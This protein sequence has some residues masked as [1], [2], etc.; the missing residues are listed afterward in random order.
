MP[1]SV[2]LQYFTLQQ[3][4][5]SPHLPRLYLHSSITCIFVYLMNEKGLYNTIQGIREMFGNIPSKYLH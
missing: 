5:K 2:T 3:Q 1:K 4:Q